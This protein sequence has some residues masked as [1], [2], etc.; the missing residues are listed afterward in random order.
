MGFNS[1]FKGLNYLSTPSPFIYRPSDREWDLSR[2]QVK[3]RVLAI[4]KLQENILTVP[5]GL[6]NVY[7]FRNLL[8]EVLSKLLTPG[9][10][11]KILRK[12][13]EIICKEEVVTYFNLS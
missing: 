3:R 9:V 12:D 7:L 2:L 5:T 11:I 4:P 1:G 13:F 8:K 6:Q 10:R